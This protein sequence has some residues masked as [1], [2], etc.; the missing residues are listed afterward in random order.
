M[1]IEAAL[2]DRCILPR[3]LQLHCW[4]TVEITNTCYHSPP[5]MQRITVY[6]EMF[7]LRNL[8]ERTPEQ[9]GCPLLACWSKLDFSH[10]PGRATLTLPLLVC[11]PLAAWGVPALPDGP[12]SLCN[13]TAGSASPGDAAAVRV[14]RAGHLRRGRHVPGEV[15]GQDQ[16]RCASV[17]S[18]GLAYLSVR[19]PT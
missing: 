1:C 10:A 8:P 12:I 5:P 14:R 2:S 4:I 18:R 3:L 6:K 11:T 16:H 13:T 17:C 19:L 9:V 15:P 7:R